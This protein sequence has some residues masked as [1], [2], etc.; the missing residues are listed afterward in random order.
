MLFRNKNMSPLIIVGILFSSA[1]ADVSH[2]LSGQAHPPQHP[3]DVN[4]LSAYRKNAFQ[5]GN[6]NDF[7]WM[8][9]NSPLKEAYDYFKKCSSKG[10]C[11]PPINVIPGVKVAEAHF[12][13]I[14]LKKNPFLNGEFQAGAVTS[15]SSFSAA[16]S[17][18]S[19]CSS[20][21]NSGGIAAFHTGTKI[22]ITNNP[23]LSGQIATAG[24]SSF[25]RFK[26]RTFSTLRSSFH[27]L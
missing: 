26:F 25:F 2:V 22:D 7:W 1:L 13:P 15:S 3:V 6:P 14:D 21:A 11:L 8:A 27:A 5:S 16:S 12:D 23:F 20:G 4:S 18:C 19:A 24:D 10:N 17:G 9:S